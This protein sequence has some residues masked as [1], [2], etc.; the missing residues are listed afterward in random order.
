MVN[1]FGANYIKTKIEQNGIQNKLANPKLRY[2]SYNST[3][4]CAYLYTKHVANIIIITDETNT[5]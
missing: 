3:F 4:G 1:L 5:I 2:I